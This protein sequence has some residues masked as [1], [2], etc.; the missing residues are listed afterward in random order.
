[1][2]DQV[3]AKGTNFVYFQEYVIQKHGKAFWDQFMAKADVQ[4]KKTWE[5]AYIGGW[6]PFVDFKGAFFRYAKMQG[7]GN[8]ALSEAY[9]F[10]ADRSLN[11]LYRLFFKAMSS[12]QFVLKNYPRLWSM[13]FNQ[14][15]VEVLEGE[16]T[17]C[18]FRFILPEVFLDWLPPACIGYTRKAVTLAGGKN[19]IVR[20]ES[21][22][23]ESQMQVVVYT[24][25]WQ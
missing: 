3:M 19:V 18:R 16:G 2:S 8:E 6:Y 22:A 9:E 12:P 20:E 13:F 1:M 15:N 25:Q 4:E 7:G 10:I 24:V 5:A 14:G 21:R 23:K 11:T 17:R